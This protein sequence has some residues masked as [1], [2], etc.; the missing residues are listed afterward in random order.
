MKGVRS[1]LENLLKIWLVRLHVHR[2]LLV[3]VLFLLYDVEKLYVQV[4]V[5]MPEK[6]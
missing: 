2:R 5:G 4:N 6:S 3:V 1:V